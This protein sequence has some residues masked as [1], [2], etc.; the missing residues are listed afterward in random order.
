MIRRHE[1]LFRYELTHFAQLRCAALASTVAG[2]VGPAAVATPLVLLQQNRQN[3]SEPPPE[4]AAGSTTS[5]H[6]SRYKSV[7]ET[8]PQKKKKKK[9]K[10]KNEKKRLYKV[11][12]KRD[13]PRK[14]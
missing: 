10:K 13:A 9:K 2:A 6:S 14:K 7:A 3:Y 12:S 11:R 4:S 8:L 1:E 5:V